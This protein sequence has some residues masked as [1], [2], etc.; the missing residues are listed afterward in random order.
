[1]KKVPY[2]NYKELT[3]YYTVQ[4]IAKLLQLTVPELARKGQQHNI[5]LYRDDAGRCLLD[6]AGVKKL[7]YKLYHES[8]GQKVPD[9]RRDARW[10]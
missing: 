2:I 4:S 9:N 8:R 10:A 1:M 3:G 7:H 5:P 6:S